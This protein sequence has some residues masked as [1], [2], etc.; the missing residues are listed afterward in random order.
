MGAHDF[1]VQY[2][3]RDLGEVAAEFTQTTAPDGK[4]VVV[5]GKCPQCSGDT[6]TEY[7]WGVP[8][9]GSKGLFTKRAKEVPD[10]LRT[11]VL[12]CECGYVH[13]NQPADPV[14]LGCGASWR[15]R[16]EVTG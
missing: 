7:S 9:T 13:P 8:G 10:V 4:G 2:V 12:F 1:D 16:P 5:K 3:E 14:F 15:V 6:A 11:E